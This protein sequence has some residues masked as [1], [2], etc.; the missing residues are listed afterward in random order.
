MSAGAWLR[1]DHWCAEPARHAL[2]TAGEVAPGEDGEHLV[3]L[4]ELLARRHLRIT[5][6]GTHAGRDELDVDAVHRQD[7]AAVQPVEHGEDLLLGITRSER[8][9][10]L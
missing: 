5:V 3:V 8:R 2:G 4:A 9:V 6:D 10:G 1:A 7:A